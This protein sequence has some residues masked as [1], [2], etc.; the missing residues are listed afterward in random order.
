MPK[1][2]EGSLGDQNTFS[3]APK[4][5]GLQSLGDQSTFSSDVRESD[6]ELEEDLELVDLSK[7]FTIERD[8]GQGGMGIVQL[9][10][11]KRLERRVAIK[12]VLDRFLTSNSARQRF[13]FGS[14]VN[15]KGRPS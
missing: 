10:Y 13:I 2:Y 9:A 3:G 1:D 12:R 5:S 8:L 15:C 7:R 6:T 14:A 4:E 11:D